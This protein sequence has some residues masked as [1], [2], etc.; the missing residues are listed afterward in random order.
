MV[1]TSLPR[2][3]TETVLKVTIVSN[4]TNSFNL[5][6]PKGDGNRFNG[7]CDRTIYS[8]I[9]FQPHYPERGQKL[10]K[11]GAEAIVIVVFQPHYPERGRKQF[12]N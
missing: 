12:K 2:K 1:S 9:L 4:P 10:I 7:Q 6:T 8:R 11:N 5:T 3:G